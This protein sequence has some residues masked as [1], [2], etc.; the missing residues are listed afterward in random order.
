MIF[1]SMLSDADLLYRKLPCS[2]QSVGVHY[3]SITVVHVLRLKFIR[4]KE[5]VV[6]ESHLI[7]KSVYA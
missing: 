1:P 4:Y 3:N 2:S 5:S 7:L 6:N